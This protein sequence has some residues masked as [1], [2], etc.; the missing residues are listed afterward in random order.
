MSRRIVRG[1]AG[2]AGTLLAVALVMAI[3]FPS[4]D[5]GTAWVALTLAAGLVATVIWAGG[6]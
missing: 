5:V 2:S 6:A 1:L 4:L 3:P